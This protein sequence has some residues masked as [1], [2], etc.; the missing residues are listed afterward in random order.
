MLRK[1]ARYYVMPFFS[2]SFKRFNIRHNAQKRGF[3]QTI[4]PNQCNFIA[5]LNSCFAISENDF[6][7]I[8]LA[9]I[10][11]TNHFPSRRCS[12]LKTNTQ[13]KIFF[14]WRVHTLHLVQ[15]L[16]FTLRLLRLTCLRLKTVNKTLL[17]G[18]VF[19]LIVKSALQQFHSFRLRFYIKRIISRIHIELL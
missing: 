6:L 4:C 1:K 13:I 17:V 15:L 3:S 18:D 2:R 10:A 16:H 19:L 5:S 9:N 14:L 8:S 11:Q 12:H 7:S